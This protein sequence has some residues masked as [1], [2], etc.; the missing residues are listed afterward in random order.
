MSLDKTSILCGFN[1]EI[2]CAFSQNKLGKIHR[3]INE[4]IV[5]Y[6]RTLKS[7]QL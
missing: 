3:I 4:F 6:N 2:F 1:R 5:K 7:K